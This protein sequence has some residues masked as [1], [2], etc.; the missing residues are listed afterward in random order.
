MT[1]HSQT[2]SQTRRK[3]TRWTDAEDQQILARYAIEGASIDLPGRSRED[4]RK[5]AK[6][7]RVRA[8]L[9]ITPRLTDHF[10]HRWLRHWPRD[11]PAAPRSVFDLGGVQ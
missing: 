1:K 4:I 8:I 6:R 9:A 10:E 5:R 7:L 3:W 2:C 11:I